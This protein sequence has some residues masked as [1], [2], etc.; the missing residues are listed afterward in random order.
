MKYKN[1]L[2]RRFLLYLIVII[3]I[4]NLLVFGFCYTI[5]RQNMTRQTM[6]V[7]YDLME[8][9]LTVMEQYFEDIDNIAAS[10]I[11][12]RDISRFMK[13][14]SDKVSDM[15]LLYAVESLYYNSR[16]D[17]RL[18]FYKENKYNNVYT[19]MEGNRAATIPDYRYTKWYQEIVWEEGN[20]VLLTNQ[21]EDNKEFVHSMIYRIEDVY[22]N[23]TVG[24]LKI[25]MSLNSLK[26]R[27]LH[28]YGQ[29]AGA[30]IEDI[31]GNIL[32]YD[33]M[34]VEVPDAYFNQKRGSCETDSFIMSF[35]VSESTGW[36]LSVAMS[37]EELFRDQ[38]KMVK[39]LIVILI[40][41]LVFTFAVSGKLFSVITVNF[42]RLVEGMHEVRNGNLEVRVDPDTADE[43]RFLIEEFNEMV[44]RIGELVKTVEGKQILL[45]EAEIKALQQQI[46]PHFMHNI[47]E[48]IM[49]LASEGMDDEVIMVSECMSRMLRYNMRFENITTLR[50]EV[51]QVQNYVKVLK[52]RFGNRFEAYFDIDEACMDCNIVKFTLQPLVENAIS[53][54]LAETLRDGIL[55]MRVKKEDDKIA[56]MI[57]DNGTGI[58]P[59]KLEELKHRLEETWEHPLDYIEQYK[60]L[61]I[62]NV[63]LRLRMYYGEEYSIELFSKVGKGTCFSIKIPY[64]MGENTSPS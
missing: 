13:N 48:T 17:L 15:E 54:G 5:A 53:H 33:K 41:I 32:F 12:N 4:S 23:K 51:K 55:R 20:K 25:D 44:G 50:E 18:Y 64:R 10:I 21:S 42:K 36:R 14:E 31:E 2:T 49:G 35:G 28:D 58:V 62:L 30:S 3:I 46:N 45:K 47:M 6:D 52:V 56:I 59:E 9:N 19:I 39:V 40:T 38:E 8:S 29:V 1:S 16:P 24:Y 61:G 26:E 7:S 63:H 34:E 57:F 37:K 11:F 22:E 60:S 43:I 27:F